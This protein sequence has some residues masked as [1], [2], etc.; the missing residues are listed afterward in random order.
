MARIEVSVDIDIEDYL[1]EVLT[2]DLIDE[3]NSR[4][5]TTRE[6]KQLKSIKEKQSG[7]ILDS[8]KLEICLN[9]FKNKTLEEL[10]QFFK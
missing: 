2:S 4:K 7:T 3:I 10:E 6:E 8:M 1:D 9:G 5:L